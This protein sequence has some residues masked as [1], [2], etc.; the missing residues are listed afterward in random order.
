MAEYIVISN[1]VASRERLNPYRD[2]HL[3]YL[4]NLKK[5]GKLIMAGR[6]SDGSGGAYF[7]NASDINEAKVIADN[8]PYHLSGLRVYTLKEWERRF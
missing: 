8:D 4:E 6:F 2:E 3:K 7:L 1:L 5:S